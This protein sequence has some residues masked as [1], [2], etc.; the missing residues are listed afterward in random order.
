MKITVGEFFEFAIE[1][2]MSL[3]S[4]AIYWALTN[5]KVDV[6]DNMEKLKK[7]AIRRSGNLPVAQN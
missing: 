2:D 3:V 4:H 6:N 7:G 5:G 1:M